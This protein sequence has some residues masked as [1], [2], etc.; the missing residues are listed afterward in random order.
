MY[1]LTPNISQESRAKHK[2]THT[3]HI[4]SQS[5][6][7]VYIIGAVLHLVK[8]AAVGE[9]MRAAWLMTVV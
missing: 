3:E 7:K 4:D 5:T 6:R 8:F 9:S 1:G 2:T